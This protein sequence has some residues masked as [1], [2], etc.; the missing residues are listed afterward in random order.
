MSTLGFNHFKHSPEEGHMQDSQPQSRGGLASETGSQPPP[1]TGIAVVSLPRLEAQ[2]WVKNLASWLSEHTTGVARVDLKRPTP[3]SLDQYSEGNLLFVRHK[4]QPKRRQG[5]ATEVRLDTDQSA[6][7]SRS[8]FKSSAGVST[9]ARIKI[10]RNCF[11][12]KDPSGLRRPWIDM[13]LGL[14]ADMDSQRVLPVARL[15]IGNLL[16]VKAFP[17]GIVKFSQTIP[18]GG[19][20]LSAKILY[21][22]PFR[23]MQSF[24]NPPSRLMIRLDNTSGSGIHLSPT[25]IEVDEKLVRFSDI[26]TV[27]AAVGLSFPRSLP[28][29][30]DDD[31]FGF[32]V[33]RLSLKSL[34]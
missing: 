31:A 11:F 6:E 7:D 12:F 33:H 29:D 1:V 18:L 2:P 3:P 19:T 25:G 28:I 13:G 30:K 22:L 21:E 17:E 26:L 34:W 23:N 24:W 9:G 4:K 27:R 20:G 16:S 14:S 10:T 32:K 5:A 8:F 15:K